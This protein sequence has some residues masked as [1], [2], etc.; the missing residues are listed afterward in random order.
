MKRFILT[1]VCL[2]IS[3]AVCR[4]GLKLGGHGAYTAG[5]D[6]EDE[7]AG[8]GAQLAVEFNDSF[9]IELAGSWV[10]DEVDIGIDVID[11]DFFTIALSAR[12]GTELTEGLGIYGGGGIDYN[13]FE[14]DELDNPDDEAGFHACAGLEIA[15]GENLELFGEY[16][17]TWVEYTV[18]SGG[19]DLD[20]TRRSSDQDYEFGLARVGL[21]LVFN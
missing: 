13:I 21:N 20:L 2:M 18:E 10:E 14:I 12:L 7:N 9:S 5:G 3:V 4:A 16:R 6:V 15:L 1:A 11:I 19:G 8:A 17:Y